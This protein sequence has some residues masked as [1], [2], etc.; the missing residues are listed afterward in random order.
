MIKC[1]VKCLHASV[2]LLLLSAANAFAQT[3]SPAAH[4]RE[5]AITFDDLPLTRMNPQTWRQITAKLLVHITAKNIPAIGFVNEGK[6]YEQGRLDTARVALLLMWLDAGL[7]LGNHSF[8]HGDLHRMAP[9]KFKADILQGEKITKQLLAQQGRRP[10]YF[11]HPFLHTG[12]RLVVK[13]EVEE[14]L[15]RHQYA[16]APVTVDNSEWI[17]ARAYDLAA[18]HN[19]VAM[20]QRLGAAYV[21]Y[22]ERKFEYF[23][24]QSRALFGY[25]IKQ[26]L[27]VH[28]NAL[29]ADYFGEVAKMLA[30]RD[31]VFIPLEA[32]LR[33][34]AYRSRDTYTGPGGL[35]WL[36][37][38]A[39][40]QGKK[41]DFFEGEPRAPE[42]VLKAAG[43]DSE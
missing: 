9:E 22:L 41:G 8:S 16:V 12:T 4:H 17:F 39:L 14:F 21:P 23:E 43:V 5:V 3:P 20:Q 42:F 31:Y 10:R 27:L 30:Q 34:Q 7:E 36:A 19:D 35:S 40:T 38:W 15:N 13:N 32:A 1:A 25:E 18:E 24:K 37:R 26:V 2:C 11:R 29:N 6:L 33:D 28:A